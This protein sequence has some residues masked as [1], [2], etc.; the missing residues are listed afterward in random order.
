MVSSAR[1]RSTGAP[2]DTDYT[3]ESLADD[4]LAL[5]DHLD[6][7]GAV[8]ALGSSMG[9]A[10]V[11]HAAVREPVR[12]SALVLLIPPTAW[13]TRQAHAQAN[14]SAAETIERQGV[15]AWLAEKAA[16]RRPAA[17]AGVPEFPPT[18]K[19]EVLPAI[20]RGLALSDL[21]APASLAALRLPVLI[22]AWEG[23]PG[24]PLSTARTLARSLP[25]AELHV[26][27]TRAGLTAWGER[28][29]AFLTARGRPRAV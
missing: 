22:L 10:T 6:A 18:P 23:D 21:P 26:S 11:L 17:V 24:H 13:T 14:R 9:C 28:A 7:P 29:A 5:L 1:P 12:F 2:V 25:A 3:Y 16:S 19:A 20:L 27:R 8:D 4:L 15:G